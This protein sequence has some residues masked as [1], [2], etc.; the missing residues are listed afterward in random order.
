MYHADDHSFKDPVEFLLSRIVCTTAKFLP[1]VMCALYMSYFGQMQVSRVK[2]KMKSSCMGGT[3][4]VL[5]DSSEES[6]VPAKACTAKACTSAFFRLLMLSLILVFSASMA[7]K[8]ALASEPNYMS[9]Y[10]SNLNATTSSATSATFN[11]TFKQSFPVQLLKKTKQEVL[12]MLGEYSVGRNGTT[13]THTTRSAKSE[14]KAMMI[15]WWI[16]IGM[17]STMGAMILGIWSL[18]SSVMVQMRALQ[19]HTILNAGAGQIKRSQLWELVAKVKTVYASK[20]CIP[21][22]CLNLLVQMLLLV[23]FV[24][25]AVALACVAQKNGDI[26]KSFGQS[27]EL[28]LATLGTVVP[29][30]F[31]VM[32]AADPLVACNEKLQK[33]KNELKEIKREFHRHMSVQKENDDERIAAAVECVE[34]ELNDIRPVTLFGLPYSRGSKLV[35]ILVL[36][37]CQLGG[38][39]FEG[40]KILQGKVA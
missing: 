23:G 15:F 2:A 25:G 28:F 8:Y 6:V 37:A 12:Q 40:L 29:L 19:P 30:A 1:V 7:F 11:H 4:N 38:A 26:Q 14:N 17:V 10:L 21:V 39:M 33:C 31:F 9:E 16:F 13:G 36:P 5:E 18:R 32:H 24:E 20:D 35:I 3:D 27:P 34:Q 22:E